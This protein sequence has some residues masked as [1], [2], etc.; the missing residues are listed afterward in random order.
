MSQANKLTG[1]KDRAPSESNGKDINM[2]EEETCAPGVWHGWN[3]GNPPVDLDTVVEVRW[4]G[5]LRKF[6]SPMKARELDWSRADDDDDIVAFC[7][8]EPPALSGE[9]RTWWIYDTV[10][11]ATFGEAKA[12]KERDLKNGYDGGRIAEVTELPDE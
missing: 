6:Y 2:S 11:Y 1:Q 9:L 8:V 10:D 3:G 12:A 4:R 7:I 5:G